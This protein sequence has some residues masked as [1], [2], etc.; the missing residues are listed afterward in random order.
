M[1]AVTSRAGETVRS[2]ALP[3]CASHEY[4]STLHGPSHIH[5]R[6]QHTVRGGGGDFRELAFNALGHRQVSDRTCLH[7]CTPLYRA[8]SRPFVYPNQNPYILYHRD[9][10]TMAPSKTSLRKQGCPGSSVN[11]C[12]GTGSSGQSARGT[13]SSA[14][15]TGRDMP[16]KG[17]GSSKA[18][19]QAKKTSP[20]H[21]DT[22]SLAHWRV[23]PYALYFCS[24]PTHRRVYPYTFGG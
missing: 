16:S 9:L 8:S 13:G 21:E 19:M 7:V 12:R 3:H 10:N 20:K 6:T 1:R 18:A 2:A 14:R 15:G 17:I 23:F 11:V 22:L 4:P 5:M 24:T